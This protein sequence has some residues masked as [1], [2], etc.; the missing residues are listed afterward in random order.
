MKLRINVRM[1]AF[2]E[3]I[4]YV[5]TKILYVK[6]VAIKVSAVKYAQKVAQNA[7]GIFP[8]FLPT[9][10]F[11]LPFMLVLC[12]NMNNFDVKIYSLNVLLEYLRYQHRC[13]ILSMN[14]SA[15]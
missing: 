1:T 12:F 15:F 4:W 3:S 7:S 11:K 9:M 13:F 14:F 6:S 8:K 2:L 5:I 10:L